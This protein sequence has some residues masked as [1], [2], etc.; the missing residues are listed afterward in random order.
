MISFVPLWEG[1]ICSPN[2][3]WDHRN[4]CTSLCSLQ[5]RAREA[6]LASIPPTPPMS[7]LQNDWKRTRLRY[8]LNVA[9]CLALHGAQRRW[10]E[11]MKRA[12]GRTWLL[13]H[14]TAQKTELMEIRAS[15]LSGWRRQGCQLV[16]HQ[17]VEY[18]LHHMISVTVWKSF[19]SRKSILQIFC[20]YNF[21]RVYSVCRT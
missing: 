1:D 8:F 10:G 15:K 4:C 9:L 5:I 7:F 12:V 6:S 17:P 13:C 18:V 19:H 21:A 16:L 14:A 3:W 11:R 20:I 2:L